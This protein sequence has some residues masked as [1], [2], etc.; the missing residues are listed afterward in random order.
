VKIDGEVQSIESVIE[1][2]VWT[3]ASVDV[4]QMTESEHFRLNLRLVHYHSEEGCEASELLC[5]GHGVS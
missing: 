4:S 3:V 5:H 1:Q 2:S